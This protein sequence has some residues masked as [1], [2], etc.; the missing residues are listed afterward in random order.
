M[1]FHMEAGDRMKQSEIKL[2][3][4][5]AGSGKT[6]RLMELVHEEVGKGLKANGLLAVTYTKKAAE[7]LKQ[8][9]REKLVESGNVDA[10]RSMSSARIGTVHGICGDILR[11][12]SFED[13]SSP[14]QK[15]I[16]ENESARLFNN[17]LNE[18]LTDDILRELSDISLK[19]ATDTESLILE[20]RKLASIIRQ[21]N[22][23]N[24]AIQES[25]KLSLG[26]IRLVTEN[27]SANSSQSNL[28]VALERF[29]S[30]HPLPP[31]TT[32]VTGTAH[33][34]VEDALVFA[35]SSSNPL[36][37]YL[38]AKL[39][40]VEA[41][42]K[43]RDFF[44][45]V[46]EA[47]RAFLSNGELRSDLE[48]MIHLAFKLANEAAENFSSKKKNLGVLDYGDLE[49]KTLEILDKIRIRYF[50]CR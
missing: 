43:S 38:W 49:Q 34:T 5:S 11:R 7:E 24:T 26:K 29:I 22:L 50:I 30:S 14:R 13:G 3:S 9:I 27:P 40:K 8:R 6:Y 48:K 1:W 2:I 23:S 39:A 25:L 21:N 12:F 46:T 44:N 47:A 16:D 41:G 4:A 17:A 10:A 35:K 15:V 31:D 42:A 20:V 32:K 36:S 19:F 37:W 45:G 18:V 33:K 28:I